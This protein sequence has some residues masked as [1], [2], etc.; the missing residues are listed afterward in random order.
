MIDYRCYVLS[1][2]EKRRYYLTAFL[3]IFCLGMLFYR[4]ILFSILCLPA[5]SLCERYWA[6]KKAEAQRKILLEGFRDVLSTLSASISAG[7]QMP[8]AIADAA[9][10]VELSYGPAAPVTFELKRMAALYRDSHGSMEE[11]LVDFGIR[12]GL[13]EIRQFAGV[14]QICSRRGGDL[15]E[16]ASISAGLILDRI[17]FR[18]ELRM[19]TA[20]KKLDIVFLISMPLLILLFLNLT[21][22][23]YLAVLYAGAAGR[24]I[25]TVCLLT[26]AVALLWGI[27]MIEVTM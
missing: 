1:K 11:M 13:E 25:M 8:E 19:L 2:E 23:G 17:R 5:A 9:A 3:V 27:K 12:S 16:V 6:E 15:E 7:R 21:A 4:S 14:C 22:P 20:Q 26:I 24:L 18:R 10:Q